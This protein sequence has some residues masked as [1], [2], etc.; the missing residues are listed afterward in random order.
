MKTIF[1]KLKSLNKNQKESN[2]L[3]KVLSYFCIFNID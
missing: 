1:K 2:K 3:K